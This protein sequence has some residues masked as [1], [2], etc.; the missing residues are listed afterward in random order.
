MDTTTILIV[1]TETFIARQVGP[2]TAN[3]WINV[4]G[5]E[6]PKHGW[7]DFVVV[8]LGWWATALLRLIHNVTGQE[9]VYFMDGPYAV[10]IVKV[11]SGTL[12]FRMLEGPDR[13]REVSVGEGE[14]KILITDLTSQ[15]RKI[16]DLCRL[17]DWWS[18][19]AETLE[20]K[21][22]E[23]EHEALHK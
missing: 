9:T 6:F 3:I 11:A 20:T 22:V 4:N 14:V 19:D 10:E 17:H 8:L 5:S 15:S 21:L 1:E 13:K 23:L 18:A 16:L 2:V 12:Q 7:N